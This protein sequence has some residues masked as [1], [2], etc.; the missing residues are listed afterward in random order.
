M[1]WRTVCATSVTR[2]MAE[3][4]L[5]SVRGL[6]IRSS[7]ARHQ[8]IVDSI[9]F[10]VGIERV[11]LVGESGSGKSLTARAVMGLLARPLEARAER[12][13]FDGEDPQTSRSGD[14]IGCA[15]RRWLWCFRMPAT[16]SIQF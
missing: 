2:T 4:P 13:E 12:L 5:L 9:S 14:G 11:A 16:P 10:D 6:T 7:A 1:H 15:A 3:R 8:P